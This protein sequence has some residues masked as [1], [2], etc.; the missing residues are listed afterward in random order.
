L[1]QAILA[2]GRF[3]ISLTGMALLASGIFAIAQSFTGQL[4]PH[5]V[6]ALGMDA[7][8]LTRHANQNLVRFMFHDRVAFGGTLIAIGMA[9][10]WLAE[11]PLLAGAA[12]AWWTLALSGTCGFLSFLAYLGYGYLDSWHGVATLLLLP[13]YVAGMWRARSLVKPGLSLSSIWKPERGK[14]TRAASLGR[15]ILLF[16]GAGLVVAGMTI[17]VVGMTFVFVPQDLAFIGLSAA[18]IHA[19]SPVL[20][21]LVAHDRAG[22]GGGLLSFGVILLMM[23]RHARLTRN[24]VELVALMGLCGFG[25]AVGVHFAI[26]Y[27]DFMH[28]LPAY[29]GILMFLGGTALFASGLREAKVFKAAR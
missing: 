5:D 20:V 14:E 27:V 26:G 11:F 1:L 16:I 4:L 2:D 24:L 29:L 18:K 7:A 28:L 19:V 23:M 25:A 15:G 9:Y 3:L 17:L 8:T 21:P 6:Q 10:W 13:V 22:F 12:W